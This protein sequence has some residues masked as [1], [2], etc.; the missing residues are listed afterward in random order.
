MPDS[1]TA[2]LGLIKPEVGASR[3]SWGSKTNENW[4]DLDQFVASAMPI[5]GMLDFA[6]PNA[7]PGWLIA[8]G[9][10]V[11]RVTYAALFA[12]LGT[13]WGA[14]DGSTTFA[15]PH[16]PGRASVGPGTVVDEAGRSFG[17]SFT[18]RGGY[19]QQSIAQ[20]NLPNYLLT[21]D[22]Q[23]VHNHTG[24]VTPAGTHSHYTDAQGTHS[25]DGH[26][27]GAGTHTHPAW[28]DAQGAH[29]HTFTLPGGAGVQYGGGGGVAGGGSNTYYT[30]NT[31]A[32]GHNVGIGEDGWHA[33]DIAAGGNH[34]HN[35]N[36]VSDHQHGI[37]WDGQHAHNVYLGGWGVPLT[38]LN[39]YITVTKIIYA[40]R[41]A[42]PATA[43]LAVVPQRRIAT[44]MRG[45]H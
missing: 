25:H 27:Y 14:G 36:V 7:P 30:N 34:A 5:G 6:G 12:V 40:G 42:M 18:Q 3:D 20:A 41:Q 45:S 15:L 44:P 35:V 37:Y 24:L 33:H 23:G 17:F 29:E 13:Y 39:P 26:T 28:T 32:H 38:V 9:R 2:V 21:T 31:G 16:T 11:S 1:Y 10:L 8:D 43:G 22:A 19:A 4:D